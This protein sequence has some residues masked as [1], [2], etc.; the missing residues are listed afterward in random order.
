MVTQYLSAARR[1]VSAADHWTTSCQ[2]AGRFH[3]NAIM[4]STFI[5]LGKQI[6]NGFSGLVHKNKRED[7]RRLVPDSGDKPTQFVTLE[8]DSSDGL[9][10]KKPHRRPE[11]KDKDK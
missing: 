10:S 5:G 9:S 11:D 6:S 3:W 1:W 2:G 7:E 4:K 8:D